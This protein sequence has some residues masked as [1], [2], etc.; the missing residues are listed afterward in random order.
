MQFVN[1]FYANQQQFLVLNQSVYL[2]FLT[3][4]KNYRKQAILSIGLQFFNRTGLSSQLLTVV[5][6]FLR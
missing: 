3:K 2:A 1:C 4:E 5:I 6:D